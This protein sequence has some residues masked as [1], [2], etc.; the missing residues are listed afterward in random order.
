[1]QEVATQQTAPVGGTC[2]VANGYAIPCND[3]AVAKYSPAGQLIYISYLRGSGD[4]NAKRVAVQEQFGSIFQAPA[5]NVYLTGE[6][7]SPDFPVTPTAFQKTYAGAPA[8]DPE[9]YVVSGD[10]FVAK[11]D[12][13][14]GA[15]LYSTYLGGPA[16]DFAWDLHAVPGADFY[17]VGS[18][19]SGL[20]VTNRTSPP[21]ACP[22]Y[23]CEAGFAARFDRNSGALR[24]LTYLPYNS[25]KTDVDSAGNLY[26]TGASDASTAFAAKLDGAGMAVLYTTYFR[27]ATSLQGYEIAVDSQSSAWVSGIGGTG[28]QGT[29]GATYF[30][31]KLDAAGKQVYHSPFIEAQIS[32]DPSDNLVLVD[33][34][35]GSDSTTVKTPGGY[36]TTGCGPGYLAKIDPGGMVVLARVMDSNGS[37]IGFDNQ[38]R[39]VVSTYQGI[40]SID[41]TSGPRAWTTC[42]YDSASMSG[43]AMVAPGE[44]VTVIGAGLGPASGV[45]S[46][47]DAEGRA[48][49]SLAG[50]RVLF[51]GVPGP[52]LYAQDGQVNAIVPFGAAPGTAMNVQVE[53]QGSPLPPLS[54]GVTATDP[55]IFTSDGS[56]TGQALA[57]N[58]DGTLNNP[59][60]PALLG[61][62]MTIFVDGLGATS[63]ASVEGAV[64]VS[65]DAR[66]VANVAVWLA[67]PSP[68]TVLYAGPSPGS[69][70]SVTQINLR[71]P[72]ALT[73]YASSWPL[74]G[75]PILIV[76]DGVYLPRGV[77][78]A[79]ALPQ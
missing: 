48:P 66:P 41:L 37:P 17:V 74:S 30:L 22:H 24:Y 63:P 78:I 56:G 47:V 46:Q 14:T 33:V 28:V 8:P 62:L 50:T 71:L 19:S 76:V 40:A 23:G 73:G 45:S 31:A 25:V 5:E 72:T 54:A 4:Q 69:L 75:M 53:Y 55:Y 59:A 79:V 77:T 61:S 2:R 10:I 44:I 29:V 38:G 43:R 67:G 12:G 68:A 32:V 60:N 35:A 27:G 16:A 42:V 11:L 1:L 36:L 70:S 57:F 21:A 39:L 51:N 58:Q 20:P 3:V 64:S 65:T 9:N 13:N 15:L 49:T 34:D 52:V 18:A 7:S 6:T 26:F